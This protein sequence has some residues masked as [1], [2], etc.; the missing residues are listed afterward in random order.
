MFRPSV[1]WWAGLLPAFLVSS[2][3]YSVLP[4]LAVD[5]A[6]H[7]F[8]CPAEAV[9]LLE[10]RDVAF[11]LFD[12]EACGSRARY[13]CFTAKHTSR[14]IREPDPP[15][16]RPDPKDGV[17]LSE[18]PQA[19]PFWPPPNE[20]LEVRPWEKTKR[21]CREKEDIPYGGPCVAPSN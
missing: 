2:G 7:E 6:S 9:R 11:G 4:Y 16:W 14:C 18:L 8:A 15:Q 5:R 10:R 19:V 17:A 3:C 12:V 13:M 21:I 20:K 1:R